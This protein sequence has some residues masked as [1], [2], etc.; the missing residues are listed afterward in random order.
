MKNKFLL[1]L[2]IVTVVLVLCGCSGEPVP[3]P[4]TDD[5]TAINHIILSVCYVTKDWSEFD[6]TLGGGWSH[7]VI[8][9]ELAGVKFYEAA[10]WEDTMAIHLYAFPN[11][12]T[13]TEEYRLFIEPEP[14][15][16]LVEYRESFLVQKFDNMPE[17][18]TNKSEFVLHAFTEF[19]KTL[20]ERHPDASHNL[21]YS[22]HGGVDEF[23]G[24]HLTLAQAITLLSHWHSA[25]GRKL[26]FVDM[27][28]PCSKGN[29][30][31]LEAIHKHA[32]YYI[33]SD[34]LVCGYIDED[35]KGDRNSM[36]SLY[37]YPRILASHDNLE[38]AL[39]ERVNLRSA[40]HKS[41]KKSIT[42]EKAMQ[43]M[44]LYSCSE[45]ARHKDAIEEFMVSLRL[46]NNDWSVDIK[47][48]IEKA[49]RQDLLNAFN[50][51]VIHGVDTKDYFPWPEERNGLFW[52]QPVYERN[53]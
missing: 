27:G 13:E 17:E 7:A 8:N 11:D 5:P 16:D 22:G 3:D 31:D 49:G 48:E 23:L 53:R 40:M 24:Q 26:G 50:S 43:S 47:H 6:S 1:V 19:A 4:V 25:L 41:G 12:Y 10:I 38:D 29:F 52:N 37:Q 2:M 44:Y 46:G 33:A 18:F 14:D 39:I 35:F 15:F 21:I 34:L 51:I 9:K 42:E 32:E 45:F 36:D 30:H 20:V 28:H